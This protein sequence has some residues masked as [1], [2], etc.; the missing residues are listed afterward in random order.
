MKIIPLSAHRSSTRGRPWDFGKYGRDRCICSSFNQ[1]GS[2][3]TH[4]L[5][6]AVNHAPEPKSA[7]PEPSLAGFLRISAATI[8]PTR[9]HQKR[10][11][12][13]L[14][15]MPR[16]CSR[17]FD[18]AKRERGAQGHH[19]RLPDG[20]VA[21]PEMSS[22]V[23]F[24]HSEALRDHSASLDRFCPDTAKRRPVVELLFNQQ[25][26]R[27]RAEI[28]LHLFGQFSFQAPC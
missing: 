8:G 6:G 21:R 17:G 19:N 2:L 4:L 24:H 13:W 14:I 10:T 25:R 27:E 11:D 5:K 12:S 18:V 15:A 7:G 1:K 26:N 20:L 28:A 16:S 23:V 22:A 9:F 3:I